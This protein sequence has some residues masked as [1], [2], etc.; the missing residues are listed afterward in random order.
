MTERLTLDVSGQIFTIPRQQLNKGPPSKLVS[1]CQSESSTIYIDRPADSFSAVIALYQTGEIHIPSSVC[2]VLLLKELRYWDISATHISKCC[3]ERLESCMNAQEAIRDFKK[4]HKQRDPIVNTSYCNTT[5]KL[6]SK[7]W[8]IIDYTEPSKAG[9]I[10]FFISLVMI[11]VSILAIA[12]SEDPAFSREMTTCESIQ[13]I[14]ATDDTVDDTFKAIMTEYCSGNDT[15]NSEFQVSTKNDKDHVKLKVSYNTTD[16]EVLTPDDDMVDTFLHPNEG[17]TPSTRDMIN[18]MTTEHDKNQPRSKIS[19][20][21]KTDTTTETNMLRSLL[22]SSTLS[23]QTAE[24][25]VDDNLTVNP[26]ATNV[27][28]L[29]WNDTYYGKQ[30]LNSSLP[31]FEGDEAKWIPPMF[32]SVHVLEKEIPHIKLKLYALIVC[33]IVTSLFFTL[34]FI[35]R[36]VSCPCIVRYFTSVINI[37]DTLALVSTHL[38]TILMFLYK[39][40]QYNYY[41]WLRILEYSQMARACRLLRIMDNVRAG[42]IL[43]YSI[44]KNRGDLLTIGLFL[45]TG[46]CVYASCFYLSEDRQ[47]VR[48]LLEAWY[49]AIITMTTVG[50]GDIAPQTFLGR[51]FAALCAVTGVLMLALTI[52]IF[53]NSFFTLY[54][55]VHFRDRDKKL[56]RWQAFIDEDSEKGISSTTHSKSVSHKSLRKK[57]FIDKSI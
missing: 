46:M 57:S 30:P 45:L 33:G 17:T 40:E 54:N 1:I 36:L 18:D 42:K 22:T 41:T 39:Y 3:F 10:Y 51:M 56:K 8:K 28:W 4:Y 53:A 6:R 24:M 2:P 29:D 38:H 11:L 13:Y 27:E 37:I 7:I 55:H 50:Y 49:W 47:D 31:F 35:L 23:S 26:E 12:Y 52:P 25:E 21:I 14:L 19:S 34:D 9:M 16:Y 15:F 5:R 20:T 44:L 48:T 32:I 43:T